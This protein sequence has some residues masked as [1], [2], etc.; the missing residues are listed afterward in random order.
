MIVSPKKGELSAQWERRNIKGKK[1]ERPRLRPE[2]FTDGNRSRLET[3]EKEFP[4]VAEDEFRGV[5]I[6]AIAQDNLA[7]HRAEV[8]LP[9]CFALDPF[10]VGV[11]GF[12]IVRRTR[13]QPGAKTEMEQFIRPTTSVVTRQH[14]NARKSEFRLTKNV[15][16][17]LA[18][19]D[20]EVDKF[21]A[22][23]FV[24]KNVLV[25]GDHWKISVG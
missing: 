24:E 23:L 21:A 22:L 7:V 19:P 11:R 8:V 17:G 3:G 6:D 14:E 2:N 13:E 25:F 5:G 16:A 10:G 9:H 1:R 20:T 18:D 4:R 15:P 12:E